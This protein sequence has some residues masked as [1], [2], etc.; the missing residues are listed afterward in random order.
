MAI[1]MKVPSVGESVS[2]VTIASWTKKEGDL[3]K[4]DEIICELETDKA[5]FELPAEADGILR[6]VAPEGTTIP[7]GALTTTALLFEYP[8]Q[9]LAACRPI[10]FWSPSVG[11]GWDC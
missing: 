2:E 11:I 4:M 1:E 7:I 8:F 3:V 10:P 5:T 6:I 9:I